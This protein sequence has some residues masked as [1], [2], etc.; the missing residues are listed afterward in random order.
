MPNVIKFVTDDAYI[1]DYK[2][3]A[4]SLK[5][6][7]EWWKKLPRHFVSQ[8]ET[9]PLMNPTMK[10]CP[11]FIDLYKNSFALPLDLELEI[12]E[13]LT[14]DNKIGIRYSPES[15]GSIHPDVQTGSAFSERYHHFKIVC[16][17]SFVT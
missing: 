8:D 1:H 5:Y 4:P 17:Y 10:G 7:P 15:A 16:R 6:A 11:G 2:P 13:F 3:M 9:Q 12:S 14:D